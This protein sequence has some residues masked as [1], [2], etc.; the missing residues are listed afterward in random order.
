MIRIKQDPDALDLTNRSPHL[1]SPTS[2]H[3]DDEEENFSAEDDT[4]ECIPKKT[5]YDSGFVDTSDENNSSI[6]VKQEQNN[7]HNHHHYHSTPLRPQQIHSHIRHPS[8]SSSTCSSPTRQEQS[9][10]KECRNTRFLGSRAVAV[11]N[12]WFQLNREY[13]YP[14]DDRTERLANEAGITQKQVKKWFANKRVRSQMCYKPLYRSR[15][16]RNSAPI[17]ERQTQTNYNY[18]INHNNIGT[19]APSFPPANPMLF[20]PMATSMMMFMMQ[21]H[22]LSTMM[23]AGH[24]QPQIA[25]PPTTNPTPATTT[26]TTTTQKTNPD[27]ITRFWL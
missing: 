7:H 1:V 19:P 26:T 15:K 16:P 8:T 24:P 11:L 18:I 20:N 13:P 23:T 21:Q 17:P 27:R 3:E 4:H 6:M 5:T 12:Q 10:D 22:F 9:N 14:D 25:P 2:E